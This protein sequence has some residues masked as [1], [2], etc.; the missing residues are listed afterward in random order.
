MTDVEN[1]KG[2]YSSDN[3]PKPMCFPAYLVVNFSPSYSP[4]SHFVTIIFP[5]K[6]KCIYFDPLNL[7]FI[8]GKIKVYMRDN[9][10]DIHISKRRKNRP[11]K[12]TFR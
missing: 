6:G 11:E 7:K 4:G 9:A 1:F 2:V 3:I 5:Q 12:K 10:K 8:P